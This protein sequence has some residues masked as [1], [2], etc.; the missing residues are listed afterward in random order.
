M[1]LKLTKNE[2]HTAYDGLEAVEAAA[3]FRPDLVLLDIGLPKL[4]GYEACRRI[5]ETAVGQEDGAGGL[6]RLGSGGRPAK[7]ERR[8]VQRPPG[9]AGGPDRPNKATGPVGRRLNLKRAF[10]SIE[11]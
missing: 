1:L 4:N 3:T 10:G 6:D 5:R 9:Q 7:V 2:T 8:R 11:P